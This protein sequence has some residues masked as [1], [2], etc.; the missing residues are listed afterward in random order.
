MLR[1]I[2]L[3]NQ[4]SWLFNFK[5]RLGLKAF[6]TPLETNLLTYDYCAIQ[7][8]LVLICVTTAIANEAST[9]DRREPKAS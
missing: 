1:A 8:E 6:K 2:L 3:G 7:H 4:F 9:R 5:L